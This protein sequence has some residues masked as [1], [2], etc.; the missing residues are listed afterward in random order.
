MKRP[1]DSD[2]DYS[3]IRDAVH[4]LGDDVF[5]FSDADPDGTIS[6]AIFGIY[7]KANGKRFDE[8]GM[9]LTRKV[10]NAEDVQKVKAEGYNEIAGL[11]FWQIYDSTEAIAE[12]ERERAHFKN[13]KI[14]DHH[15]SPKE[16]SSDVVQVVNP[17]LKSERTFK[18]M[19]ELLYGAVRDEFKSEKV[20]KYARD[21]NAIGIMADYCADGGQETL[22]EVVNDYK[23]IFPQL[24]K[25][26]DENHKISQEDLV[27][28]DFSRFSE[29]FYAPYIVTRGDAGVSELVKLCV[30]GGPFT[31]REL[32]NDASSTHPAIRA[33]SR[34]YDECNADVGKSLDGFK[35]KAEFH[36]ESHTAFYS[37]EL[38]YWRATSLLSNKTVNQNPEWIIGIK[39]SG[40]NGVTAYD[41]RN[42]SYDDVP[43]GDIFKKMGIGG[44]HEKAAGCRLE[45]SREKYFEHAFTEISRAC[46]NER[47][48]KKNAAERDATLNRIVRTY[49]K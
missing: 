3:M 47:L 43:L 39:L 46:M 23:D 27:A 36:D 29:M 6:A 34:A 18:N 44:G 21:L 35:S 20:R 32:L 11:D 16:L 41:F 28:S 30:D 10:I 33:M 40:Y 5:L 4:S 26:L 31:L 14:M 48:S 42:R 45:T 2:S 15:P 24:K 38:K 25:K 12:I 22:A 7:R 9:K 13:V 17:Y 37:P 8:K 19:T 1:E 49:W